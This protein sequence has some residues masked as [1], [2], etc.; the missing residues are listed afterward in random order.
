MYRCP[1]RIHDI[2]A[3]TTRHCRGLTGAALALA[4][5]AS[6]LPLRTVEWLNA[7][8]T[9]PD[10]I[11]DTQYASA[12]VKKIKLARCGAPISHF[13]MGC[14]CTEPTAAIVPTTSNALDQCKPSDKRLACCCVWVFTFTTRRL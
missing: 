13:G 4:D 2:F 5:A 6:A 7:A 11:F 3:F 1:L 9:S 8:A 12:G 14:C 10:D